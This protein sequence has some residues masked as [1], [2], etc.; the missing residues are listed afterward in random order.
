MLLKAVVR[1]V[2][3]SYPKLYFSKGINIDLDLA[4]KQH[5]KYIESLKWLG[6][7]VD[8]LPASE[9]FSDCVFIEDTAVVNDNKTII[10]YMGSDYRRGEVDEVKNYFRKSN[11]VIEMV[12]PAL[13]E[14][15][16]V[17]R[18]DKELYV[19]ISN[20]TNDLALKYLKM[21]FDSYIII[22]IP[23]NKTLHLKTACTYIGRNVILICEDLLQSNFFKKFDIIS[24]PKEES[25]AA[26]CIGI[27][28]KV[29]VPAGAIKTIS[30]IKNKGF[31]VKTVPIS[32]FV[33][34][35]GSLTCLSIIY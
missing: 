7:K 28:D 10:T 23:I 29:I 31:E 9:K 35:E 22:P 18:T 19:G 16:D 20:V 26:N 4:R 11:E 32:E 33:K 17:L 5:F 8:T 6:L 14:G 2:P 3:S 12:P 21:I 25:Y 1:E 27:Q 34:G 13:L 15:G 30:M 24:V